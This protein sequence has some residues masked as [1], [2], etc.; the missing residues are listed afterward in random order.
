MI[1]FALGR[2]LG[3][4]AALLFAR[5]GLGAP[6]LTT[7]QDTLYRADGTRFTGTVSITWNNFQS[8]EGSTVA[9]QGITI[10]VYAGTFKLQLVPTTT[11][12]P[13]ANYM[14]RYSSQ[15]QFLFSELWAVPPSATPLRV[16]DVRIAAGT[17]VGPPPILTQV[18]ITDVVGLPNELSLRPLK[19]TGY[20]GGRVAF[21]NTTGQIEGASGNLSD[22]LHV[23]GTS[24]PCGSA[25]AGSA[26][27]AGFV[28]SE[29][30]AS[31]PNNTYSL[32]MAPNPPTSLLLSRNGLLLRQ[33]LDYTLSGSVISFDPAAIPQPGD[34]L[35]ASYRIGD[36]SNPL[37]SFSAPQVICSG[38]GKTTSSTTP[39]ALGTCTI[40]ANLLK[41]GDRIEFRADAFHQGSAS[42]FTL[43]ALWGTTQVLSGSGASSDLF[44][45]G[46][47]SFGLHPS[48]AQW[49]SEAWVSGSAAATSSGN[50]SDSFTS[51]IQMKV[52]GSLS[53]ASPDAVA[54]RS[55]TVL[56]YPA[57]S[58]P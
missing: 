33:G 36:P 54:L 17:S 34:V 50:A 53:V 28:D 49:S 37:A 40:P 1:S 14:V 56:R 20:A 18:Q 3:L 25:T 22:C 43:Q 19:G 7:I 45:S 31:G 48:G 23:D 41:P 58:N 8:Q 30:P 10:Q 44:L 51:P 42:G 13:G 6:A 9:S 38:T 5:S 46:R 24:G 32:T 12:S 52:L 15:G 2:R 55:F 57:Q 26:G 29:I 16:S 47:T 39:T 27:F 4:A 11:A 21:I 35:R